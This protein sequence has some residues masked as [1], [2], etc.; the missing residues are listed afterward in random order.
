MNTRHT[1][2]QNIVN[3]IL[4]EVKKLSEAKSSDEVNKYLDQFRSKWKGC[5]SPSPYV[6]L[7]QFGVLDTPPEFGFAEFEGNIDG[8]NIKVRAC[9]DKSKLIYTDGKETGDRGTFDGQYY[10]DE[11]PLKTP[12]PFVGS[13]S[14][15]NKFQYGTL[16]DTDDYSFYTDNWKYAGNFIDG[17]IGGDGQIIFLDTKDSYKGQFKNGLIDGTGEYFS[18]STGKKIKGVFKQ[19][20]GI[21]SVTTDD[22]KFIRNIYDS[23][24]TSNPIV[25][26]DSLTINVRKSANLEGVTNF[27]STITQGDVTKTF[28]GTIPNVTV[29]LVRVDNKKD[30]KLGKSDKNGNFIIKDINLGVYNLSAVILNDENSFS[31]KLDNLKIDEDYEFV[32]LILTPNKSVKRSERTTIDFN[33]IDI[34]KKQYNSTWY[35]NLFV[36]SG[37]NT[38]PVNKKSPDSLEEDCLIK[39]KEYGNDLKVMHQTGKFPTTLGILDQE[40]KINFSD[41][42]N[43]KELV[44]VK[45]QLQFCWNTFKNARGF[46]RKVGEKNILLMRNPV[47]QFLDFQLIL[48]EHSNKQDIYNKKVMELSKTIHKVVLEHKQKKYDSLSESK[49]VFNRLNFIVENSTNRT[50]KNIQSSLIKEKNRMID[51]GYN[52][53][54]VNEQFKRVIN[55]L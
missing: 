51:F 10:S 48:P 54:I 31:L 40:K 34:S 16:Q 24:I 36:P 1:I 13:E 38:K 39:L 47:G 42:K 45:N 25:N 5:G 41:L 29:K 2:S 49:I 19:N 55:E 32:N 37:D 43:S 33:S 35:K 17:R 50:H 22:G 11:E 44:D 20:D 46:R 9:F 12:R 53:I 6:N 23:T 3:S 4:L 18:A 8:S 28:E 7:Y 52:E 30:I 27:K 14:K 21:I 15:A 26:K